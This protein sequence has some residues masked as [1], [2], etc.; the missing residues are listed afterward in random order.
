MQS[1][2]IDNVLRYLD[3]FEKTGD[4]FYFSL[5]LDALDDLKKEIENN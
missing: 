5:A 4:W 2:L 3:E 1:Q